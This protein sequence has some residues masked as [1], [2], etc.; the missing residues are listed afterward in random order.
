MT[1]HTTRQWERHI[2]HIQVVTQLP[3]LLESSPALTEIWW[4]APLLYLV[5]QEQWDEHGTC[6]WYQAEPNTGL[7]RLHGKGTKHGASATYVS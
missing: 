1:R 3:S 4:E 5:C 6:M 2:V 7:A